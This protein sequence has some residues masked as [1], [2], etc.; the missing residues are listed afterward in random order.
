MPGQPHINP[1]HRVLVVDDHAL[2]GELL[3]EMIRELG[4]QVCAIVYTEQT[5][6]TSAARCRPDLVI[7]DAHLGAGCG[8]TAMDEILRQAYVAHIFMS[9]NIRALKAARPDAILL[10]K[11]FHHQALEQSI[12]LARHTAPAP[13]SHLS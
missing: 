4:H 6:I 8:L 11:P 1:F 5:A 3:A 12:H 2:I 7:I 13:V 9:G 10:C